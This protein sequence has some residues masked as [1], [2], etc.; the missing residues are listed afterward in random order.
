MA[1]SGGGD[2]SSTLGW[3]SG[4]EREKIAE[5]D[6]TGPH[7]SPGL[8][9]KGEGRGGAGR[10]FWGRERSLSRVAGRKTGKESHSSVDP[11]CSAS[12]TDHL[13]GPFSP[14]LPSLPR[15]QSPLSM[16]WTAAVASPLV[17]LL[18][19]RHSLT[20]FWSALHTQV[21]EVFQKE[22]QLM[23]LPCLKSYI[24]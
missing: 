15:S 2:R 5:T 16:A 11:V 23:L 9:R 21:R 7:P 12:Q 6:Q 13:S 4:A 3:E 18:P 10:E 20:S 14:F 24:S 19:P 8:G 17:P 1:G 22:I